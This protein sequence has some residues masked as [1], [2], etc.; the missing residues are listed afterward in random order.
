MNEKRAALT[1]CLAL[2]LGGCLVGPDFKPPAPPD[3]DAYRTP[4]LPA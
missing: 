2:A 1:F 4:E 3:V